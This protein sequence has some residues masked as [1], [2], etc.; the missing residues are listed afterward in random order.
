MPAWA[1]AGDEVLPRTNLNRTWVVE[2]Y[3]MT[4]LWRKTNTKLISTDFWLSARKLLIK[5]NTTREEILGATI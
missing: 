3:K 2:Q 1:G 5:R 4:Q